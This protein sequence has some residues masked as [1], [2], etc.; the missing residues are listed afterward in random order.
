MYREKD[1]LTYAELIAK[2]GV[3]VQKGQPVY[4]KSSVEAAEFTQMV[5][6]ACWDAGAGD[7]RIRY[8]DQIAERM[9]YRY[10]DISTISDIPEWVNAPGI[11]MLEKGACLI[12]IIAEDPDAY[13]GIDVEKLRAF[14]VAA[15]KASGRFYE[16]LNKNINQWTVV[17]VPCVQ[18]AKKLFPT[19]DDISAVNRLWDCI[20]H[21]VRID[22]GD[23]QANWNDHSETLR[24]HCEKL[25]GAKLRKLH[26]TNGIG[27]DL[28]VRLPEGYIFEGG[29]SFTSD[30]NIE[31]EA[32][33]P[34]EEVYT[35]PHKYGVDGTVYS[36]MPL[37]YNGKLIDN[38][39]LTFK[40]GKV[41][42]YDA[43]TGKEMLAS[44]FA[45]DDGASRLGEIALVPYDSMIR[46]TGL[47]FYNTLF[48]ENAACH[49]ALGN[50][51]PSNLE[52]CVDMSDSEKDSAGCNRSDTHVDFMFGTAD[53]DIVGTLPDG[54]EIQVFKNGNWSF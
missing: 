3:N 50:A 6:Q 11:D 38:F 14:G 54:S 4:I 22:G 39:H 7:V 27:T 17:A 36:S 43:E 35:M 47:L 51:Y 48:D 42:D 46:E 41:V 28:T 2:V 15:A 37:I 45:I 53:L 44:I 19:D 21:T 29:S 52:G 40:D 9:R 26:I 32:N 20:Y 1:A 10:A 18:W 31:F 5:A 24:R 25:N 49:L 8:G 13:S 23:A 33:M 34:T 12:S 30:K 16:L